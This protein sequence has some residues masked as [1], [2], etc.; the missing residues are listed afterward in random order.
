MACQNNLMHVE[1]NT[2]QKLPSRTAGLQEMELRRLRQSL[3]HSV[4][5]NTCKMYAS[6]WRAF[7]SWTQSRGTLAIP[8]SPPTSWI[9]PKTASS[10][11]PSSFFTRPL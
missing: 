8:A 7:Q 5:D 4:S 1:T 9:F 3:H 11:W 6:A 10:R 2:T